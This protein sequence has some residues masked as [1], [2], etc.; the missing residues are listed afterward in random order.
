MTTSNRT[1]CGSTLELTGIIIYL[2]SILY[3]ITF[4]VNCDNFRTAGKVIMMAGAAKIVIDSLFL[5]KKIPSYVLKNNLEKTVEMREVTRTKEDLE[6]SLQEEYENSEKVFIKQYSEAPVY[7]DE[8]E[9]HT[10]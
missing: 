1:L 10:K 7:Y 9:K 4:R 5:N 8:E 2:C 3:E 6:H